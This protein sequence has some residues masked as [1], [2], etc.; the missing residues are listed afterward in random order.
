MI[1]LLED[2]KITN[3]SEENRSDVYPES[4]SGGH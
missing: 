1:T 2:T 3:I 4:L